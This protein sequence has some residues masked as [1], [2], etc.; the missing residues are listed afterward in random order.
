DLLRRTVG[1]H[2]E[3]VLLL[4]VGAFIDQQA[5]HLLAFG[6]GLVRLQLHAEDLAGEACDVFERP[7]DLDAAALAAAAG[8]D[9]RLDDPDRA[10]EPLRG[11]RGF[12]D[13]E[14]GIAARHGNAEAGKDFLALVFVDLH[15]EAVGSLLGGARPRRAPLRSGNECSTRPWWRTSSGTRVSR[16]R[17]THSRSGAVVVVA[18]AAALRGRG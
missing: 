8:M 3:V 9:L 18:G 7:G 12:T 17:L 13:A 5:P 15:R 2:C 16:V 1:E 10:A 6:A 4:D 14:S 11:L